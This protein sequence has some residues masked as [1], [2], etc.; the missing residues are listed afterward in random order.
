VRNKTCDNSAGINCGVL[1]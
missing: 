1:K